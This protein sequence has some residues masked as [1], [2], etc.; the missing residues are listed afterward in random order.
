MSGRQQ[1]YLTLRQELLRTNSLYV[2]PD[3]P[4]D[5]SSLTFNRTP[6][7]GIRNIVWKRPTVSL[8]QVRKTSQLLFHLNPSFVTYALKNRTR[9][10]I[11]FVCMYFCNSTRW[12]E[13]KV[14]DIHSLKAKRISVFKSITI[15][16]GFTCL[17]H[18]SCLNTLTSCMEFIITYLPKSTTKL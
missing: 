9:E 4:P 2:D 7:P 5:N 16:I 15:Q 17:T 8:E 18:N 1:D 11:L 3:F 10:E 6:P 13:L 12:D 14:Q